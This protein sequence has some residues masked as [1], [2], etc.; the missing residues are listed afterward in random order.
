MKV[1]LLRVVRDGFWSAPF[2]I[3]AGYLASTLASGQPI[4]RQFRESIKSADNRAFH[5]GLVALYEGEKLPRNVPAAAAEDYSWLGTEPFLAIAHALGPQLFAGPNSL[6]TFK[7]GIDKGFR[8]FEVDLAVTS[9]NQLICYHESGDGELDH[10]SS[11][12]Y[13][14]LMAKQG[15]A[16]CEFNDLVAVAR[17]NR[18][19]RFILDVRNKFDQAYELARAEIGDPGLGKSF[20][21]QV[22]FYDQLTQFRGRP[23]FAGE[24]YTS[25][26]SHLTTETI[27]DAARRFGVPVVTLTWERTRALRKLPPDLI[28][29]THSIDNA[30]EGA[31]AR[32]LGVR[33]IYTSYLSPATAP[34]LFEPWSGNCSPPEDWRDCEFA[35]VH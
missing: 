29:L 28:V 15:R 9:D 10:L 2:W 1:P 34:E 17:Q 35:R 12:Q 6:V 20:V 24:I 16:P 4:E 8:L 3:F 5:G 27:F 26:R 23:F 33:G 11:A 30:S 13:L 22:Y 18:R 7:E 31:Q 19:V 14:N 21:P 25:Y 32:R